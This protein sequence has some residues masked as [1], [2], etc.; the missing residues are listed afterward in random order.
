MP[1]RTKKTLVEIDVIV[2]GEVLDEL[3]HRLDPCSPSLQDVPQEIQRIISGQAA[4]V[5]IPVSSSAR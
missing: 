4:P 1:A 5:R 2:P 3:Q